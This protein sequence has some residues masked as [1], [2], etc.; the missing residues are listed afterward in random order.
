[1]AYYQTVSIT[2]TGSAGSATGTVDVSYPRGGVLLGVDINFHASAP[3][4]TD[5]TIADVIN[6]ARSRTLVFL[7]NANTDVYV[8]VGEEIKTS[9][10]AATGV[11]RSPAFGPL[12]R[13]SVAG[14]DALTDAVVV[15]LLVEPLGGPDG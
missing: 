8:P 3:N 13:V 9:L 15:S 4:T 6:S 10:N 7:E 14:C 12:L 5:V 11:Y 2:T 1:M